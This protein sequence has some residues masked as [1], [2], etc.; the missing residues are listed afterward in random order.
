MFLVDPPPSQGDL[1]FRI[2]GFPVRIHPFFWVSTA[3]LGLRGETAPLELVIWVG[4]VLV[5][6]TVHELGHAFAQ[7]Y[8]GGHPWITLYALGGMASCDDCD[9]GTKSQILISLAGPAA[10]FLLAI[11]T[12]VL[13]RSL[14]YQAGIAFRGEDVPI[15]PYYSLAFFYWQV[16]PNPNANL[17]SWNLLQVNV[18]WGAVN[19]LPV[20]PLDGGRVSRELCVFVNPRTGI[21]LSLQI[22]MVAAILMAVYGLQFG[23]F[24]SLFFG[25][26]AYSS[27]QGLRG[28]SRGW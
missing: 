27:Y 20:Y 26:L 19:L 4:V 14:G 6:I 21:A 7:R 12:L 24:V 1:H 13:L 23:L 8:Y 3:L 25:Y 9:R 18:L 28:Y 15:T 17:L 5:S 16:L 2:A 11:A 10:G 22:S